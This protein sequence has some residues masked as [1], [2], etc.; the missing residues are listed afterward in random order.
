MMLCS[1]GVRLKCRGLD[2]EMWRSWVLI[3]REGN[4]GDVAELGTDNKDDTAVW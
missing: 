1:S 2:I 3:R 4:C